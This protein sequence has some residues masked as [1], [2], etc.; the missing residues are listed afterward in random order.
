MSG[1]D[2]LS[3]EERAVVDVVRDFVDRDVRPVARE[4]EHANRYPEQL[5]ER[6]KQLGVLD[7]KSVV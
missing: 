6:M 4:S 5:V 3:P 2:P 1:H 7:R